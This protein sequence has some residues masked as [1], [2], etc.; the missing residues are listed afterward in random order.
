[1]VQDPEAIAHTILAMTKSALDTSGQGK[2]TFERPTEGWPF[3]KIQE[4][5][6]RV[7]ADAESYGLRVLRLHVGAEVAKKL[8]LD[9][10]ALEYRGVPLEAPSSVGATRIKFV[11][12]TLA[13]TQ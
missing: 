1:M 13:L 10:R 5:V 4:V 2:E 3:G 8:G 6:D 12:T 7:S 11:L 9:P